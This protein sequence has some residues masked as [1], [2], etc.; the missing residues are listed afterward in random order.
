M[1]TVELTTTAKTAGEILNEQKTAI[2]VTKLVARRFPDAVQRGTLWQSEKVTPRN[3]NGLEVDVAFTGTSRAAELRL[4]VELR[5][6]KGEAIRVYN[7][8]PF[9]L[10]SERVT[11]FILAN[12]AAALD[13]FRPVLSRQ[14]Q[15]HS[16]KTD[17][18]F[19]ELGSNKP[20][21]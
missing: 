5:P 10:S 2:A 6:K 11:S 4:Y 8:M 14:E 21:A 19:G 12:Q 13:H 20:K 3:A 18:Q 7:P 16:V 17:S 9:V 15:G 1:M